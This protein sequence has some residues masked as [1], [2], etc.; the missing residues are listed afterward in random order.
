MSIKMLKLYECGY[1]T[2]PE[3]IVNPNRG[4]KSIAFPAI[5]GL[6]EHSELGYILFDTGYAS[7]F[8]K[9]TRKF[10]Y[11][12]YA[13]LTPVYFS[14]EKSIKNQLLADGISPD[15]I[16]IIL[17]SH[18][19]GDHTAGLHDF[20][21]AKVYT[22]EAA[23][24]DI[25]ED[26]KF[27]ALTKGCLKDLLPADLEE[28]FTFLDRFSPIALDESFGEFQEGF[29]VFGDDSVIAVDLTGHA[30]GQFGIFIKLISGKRVFLCADAVW[31]SEA[32]EELIY[33][34]SIANLLI[35]DKA[36]YRSNI[37]KLHELAKARPQIDI[38]PTHCSV[39]WEKAK[40]GF[41]YE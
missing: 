12:V 36:K 24:K 18:F 29:S 38:L 35:A 14:E 37:M 2:H 10:P 34:H 11:S 30:I 39:T 26:S 7:H 20:P 32:F 15:Q 17:L 3:K 41:V 5:V 1:C 40:R 13:K 28:R 9:A 16:G 6:L 25:Q 31:V 8:L 19:H 23:Y 22:F 4:F 21:R 27:K 33:P